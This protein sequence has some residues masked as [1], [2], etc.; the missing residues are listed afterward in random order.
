M[1]YRD[2]LDRIPE[3]D[4]LN[5]GLKMINWFDHRDDPRPPGYNKHHTTIYRDG[6]RILDILPPGPV[7]VIMQN[8][9]WVGGRGLPTLSA[10][11]LGMLNASEDSFA[12]RAPVCDCFEQRAAALRKA[13]QPVV[14][15]TERRG[16]GKGEGAGETGGTSPA[17]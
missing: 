13:K 3:A 4:R 16:M 2:A 14:G 5:R 7:R 8:G 1:S 15:A 10:A 11:Q 9:V 6:D 17:A 12:T